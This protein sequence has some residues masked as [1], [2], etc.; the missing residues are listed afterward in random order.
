[1]N[2]A[3]APKQESSKPQSFPDGLAIEWRELLAPEAD[4]VYFKALCDFLRSEYNTGTSVFPPRDKVLRALQLVDYSQ[5]KVV[6]LGQDPYHGE[7]QATGLSFGVPDALRIKPPSLLNIFKELQSD[8]NFAWDKKESELTGWAKQGVLLLNAVLSVR[9]S[10]AFSHQAK[11]WEIF[12]DRVISLLNEREHGMVFI[13]W[14]AAAQKKKALIT[15]KRH[16]LIQSPHPSPLSAH[17][18][19]FGSRPF[20]KSNQILTQKLNLQAIDWTKISV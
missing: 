1:M 13:L 16:Y 11:G 8:L 10:Q 20:S 2:S 4:K 3:P 5:T 6:I 19:F 18:G 14:G 17:R 12:T 9:R 15:N 7:S